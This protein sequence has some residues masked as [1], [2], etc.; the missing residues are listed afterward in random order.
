MA[1][2]RGDIACGRVC[3]VYRAKSDKDIRWRWLICIGSSIERLVLENLITG[4]YENKWSEI[5]QNDTI[6]SYVRGN[7]A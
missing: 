1:E 3:G 6:Y 4:R 5:L 2:I 7:A